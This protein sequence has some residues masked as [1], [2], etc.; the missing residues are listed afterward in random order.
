[1]G[2]CLGVA[3]ALGAYA[4]FA[5]GAPVVDAPLGVAVVGAAWGAAACFALDTGAA[6]GAVASVMFGA[7]AA[8]LVL[9]AGRLAFCSARTGGVAALRWGRASAFD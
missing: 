1:M 5:D 6:W 7:G 3:L 9:G 8:F 4:C 2:V